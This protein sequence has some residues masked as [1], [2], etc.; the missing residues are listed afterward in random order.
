M[1]GSLIGGSAKD[2]SSNCA[3]ADKCLK[4]PCLIGVKGIPI[5]FHPKNGLEDNKASN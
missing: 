2:Y 3:H 4:L 1:S 5:C